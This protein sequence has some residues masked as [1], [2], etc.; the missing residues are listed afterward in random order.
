[1][2]MIHI[3]TL[4]VGPFEENCSIIWKNSQAILIDPGAEAK[5]IETELKQRELTVAAI[6]CTHGHADHISA[7]AHLSDHHNAAVYMH[8]AD[9]RWAFGEMNQIPPY[10]PTPKKPAVPIE[11]IAA[12]TH[13]TLAEMKI[14]VIQTPGHTPGSVCLHFT[15]DNL[16]IA[17]DTLFK[18][19]CGRTDLPGGSPT[20]LKASLQRLKTLPDLTRVV[21]GHG[22]DTT[23]GEEKA[24]NFFMR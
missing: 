5:R 10:Y 20:Q 2:K 18:G 8:E 16:L 14:E 3:Q 13:W 23:I 22:P 4:P 1:M 7:L 24:Y 12:Q 21:A 17:G 6:L 19:S 11:H 15:E 9:Q